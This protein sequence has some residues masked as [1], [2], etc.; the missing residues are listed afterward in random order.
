MAFSGQGAI[1]GGS[2]G[3][4][5]GPW[6]AGIGA[7]LGGFLSGQGKKPKG[8][9]KQY[10]ENLGFIRRD[11]TPQIYALMNA[12]GLMGQLGGANLALGQ[13]AAGAA[14]GGGMAGFGGTDVA[15]AL[16]RGYAASQSATARAK[17]NYDANMQFHN[18][19]AGIAGQSGT[20][21]GYNPNEYFD[22]MLSLIGQYM[23]TNKAQQVQGGYQSP[24]VPP[25]PYPAPGFGTGNPMWGG[26]G[27]Q[28]PGGF[29]TPPAASGTGI[30]YRG[31]LG[32]R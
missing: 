14:I 9:Q 26:P 31:N 17:T 27:V 30:K 10:Q 16:S 2:A 29:G 3:S 15:R 28:Y 8:P 20:Q 21:P 19:A 6:G 32:G 7:V 4:A 24:G 5:F 11:M 22:R 1:A 25:N 18:T 12:Q 23:L 13:N